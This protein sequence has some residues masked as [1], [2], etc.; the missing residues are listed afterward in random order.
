MTTFDE[1]DR[2][3]KEISESFDS[4]NALQEIEKTGI[5]AGPFFCGYTITVG[6]PS[7][8]V[9]QEYGGHGPDTLSG[10]REPLVD[11]IV[12]EKG[13]TIKLVTEMPGVDKKDIKIVVEEKTVDITAQH[14]EKNYHVTVPIRDNVEV[15]TAKASYKNGVLEV[16]FKRTKSC[17]AGKTLEVN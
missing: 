15:D 12:D 4:E 7:K 1:I 17:P 5:G 2:L 6:A 10:G 8:P 9:V 11:T 14:G 16:S 13:N 3:F